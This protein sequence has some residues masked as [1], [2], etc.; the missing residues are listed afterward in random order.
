MLEG[1]GGRGP[2]KDFPGNVRNL[3]IKFGCDRL[4]ILSLT[5]LQIVSKKNAIETRMLPVHFPASNSH[6]EAGCFL[7][8]T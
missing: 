8:K 5:K 3:F 1:G 4:S 6:Y 7:T 2:Q